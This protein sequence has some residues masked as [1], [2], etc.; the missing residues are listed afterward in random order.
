[1]LPAEATL[2]RVLKVLQALGCTLK[3]RNKGHIHLT[4]KAPDSAIRNGTLP[5]HDTILVGTLHSALRR[6]GI[7]AT[8]FMAA[9]ERA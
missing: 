9:Y 8:E 3:R 5:D 1:M 7:S 2:E 4:R 6:L